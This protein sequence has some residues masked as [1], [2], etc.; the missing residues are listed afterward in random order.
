MTA[1]DSSRMHRTIFKS[2]DLKYSNTGSERLPCIF[3][4][5]CS[6]HQADPMATCKSR[7][8]IRIVMETLSPRLSRLKLKNIMN[9]WQLHAV[10][11]FVGQSSN[12]NHHLIMV[13]LHAIAVN[14]SASILWVYDYMIR[15]GFPFIWINTLEVWSM[16][17]A[18]NQTFKFFWVTCKHSNPT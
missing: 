13:I 4:N 11:F 18:I 16:F 9:S 5:S 8:R 15:K 2:H 6:G 1:F 14:L 3:A 7:C 17:S 12:T 10:S